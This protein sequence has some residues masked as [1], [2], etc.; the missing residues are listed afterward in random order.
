VSG[1]GLAGPRLFEALRFARRRSLSPGSRLTSV[2]ELNWL[3]EAIRS[4]LCSVASWIAILPRHLTTAHSGL[5]S[6]NTESLQMR[7]KK[8]SDSVNEVMVR[9]KRRLTSFHTQ[10]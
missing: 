10:L 7:T 2:A 3:R 4:C 6:R 9:T 5:P 8:D 1:E